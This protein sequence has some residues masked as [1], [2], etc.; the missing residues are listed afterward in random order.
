MTPMEQAQAQRQQFT[1]ALTLLG[2]FFVVNKLPV[3]ICLICLNAFV[4]ISIVHITRHN[5]DH[6][7][8]QH[9][10]PFTIYSTLY[11]HSVH[12]LRQTLRNEMRR[13]VILVKHKKCKK[14]ITAV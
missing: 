12:N 7:K 13:S 9:K 8:S 2:Q 5:T 14:N 3:D 11:M 6:C 10:L 4:Y 1:V